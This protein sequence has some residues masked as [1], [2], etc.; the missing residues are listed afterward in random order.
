M[1]P[2]FVDTHR[3]TW[4]AAIRGCA[5]ERDARRLLRRGPGQLR[6]ALPARGRLREQPGRR[7]GVHQRRHH[8]ARRLVAHQQHARASGRRR[9]RAC[10]SPASASLYAY[11]SAN[12]SLADY[13]FNSTIAIPR[14]DVR[15]HPRHVLLLR[16]R[17]AD[18]GARHPRPR[19]L[20]G[21][22]GAG[23]SG[24]WPATSASRSP[25]TSAMGRLAGTLRHGQ[26]ARAT[27]GLL[28]ADTTYIHCCYFSDEEW[29]LVADTGG[30]ISIA[31]AGRDADGP[32]L[33]ADR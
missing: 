8:H 6:A 33:A 13:W 29:E 2:G 12:T 24:A 19:L 23:A 14:D 11:G 21:R 27:S 30:T 7:A 5:P 4:E 28:G 25:C 10:R 22:R 15:A 1:I 16:R 26:A 32:R 17:P 18:D 9:S 20:P 3:H 31:A